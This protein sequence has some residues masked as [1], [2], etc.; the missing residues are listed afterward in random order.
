MQEYSIELTN[1]QILFYTSWMLQVRENSGTS[2]YSG[3]TYCICTRLRRTALGSYYIHCMRPRWA[4]CLN[5]LP[6][7]MQ[8]GWNTE[9]VACKHAHTDICVRREKEK[10]MSLESTSW[11][12]FS[13]LFIWWCALSLWLAHHFLRA[14]WFKFQ[15]TNVSYFLWM[16]SLIVVGLSR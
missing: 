15:K 3:T 8:H 11:G 10:L 9:I 5:Y 6:H 13:L 14:S 12:S 4:L 1:V 2:D 16:L 7:L